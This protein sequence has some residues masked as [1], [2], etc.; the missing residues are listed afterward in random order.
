MIVFAYGPTKFTDVT[1]TEHPDGY[2]VVIS[3]VMT[4]G[5]AS[6]AI[7][8]VKAQ[9]GC[10]WLDTSLPSL[11]G[12]DA[13]LVAGTAD[14]LARWRAEWNA[15]RAEEYP[16]D[17]VMRWMLSTER[18]LSSM[19]LVCRLTGR[20]PPAGWDRVKIPTPPAPAF[21]TDAEAFRRC[22]AAVRN[23]G[24]EADLYK[25]CALPTA[26]PVF[27]R[28]ANLLPRWGSLAALIDDESR[29][30]ELNREIE[31]IG[32]LNPHGP[33]E[34]WVRMTDEDGNDAHITLDEMVHLH[35]AEMMRAWEG[36]GRP[37]PRPMV[38]DIRATVIRVVEETPDW[39]LD[40]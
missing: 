19:W 36:A 32:R 31:N 13:L 4:P 23:L 5:E 40:P 10:D 3:G 30:S 25:L 24:L 9:Y 11:L 8:H 1:Y 22:V 27:H 14:G 6:D 2:G 16:Y 7:M 21:P 17:P 12:G 28:W 20:L 29:W 39:R 35:H 33:R 38:D 26:F 15:A 18:G 34:V 37:D